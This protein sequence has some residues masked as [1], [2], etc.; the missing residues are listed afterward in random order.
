LCW[1]G[2]SA[3]QP[4]LGVL[5]LLGANLFDAGLA[6]HCGVCVF[7]EMSNSG[8]WVSGLAGSWFMW[9]ALLIS[10]YHGAMVAE[11]ASVLASVFFTGFA[12]PDLVGV[13]EHGSWF[14][15]RYLAYLFWAG[16]GLAKHREFG[17]RRV[18]GV[19]W[20]ARSF[21]EL[22]TRRVCQDTGSCDYWESEIRRYNPPLHSNFALCA[23][24]VTLTWT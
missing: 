5:N 22:T 16:S 1:D 23:V 21:V 12:S 19:P 7:G 11:A 8:E 24:P 2:G 4:T 13:V 9:L 20:V 6:T 10:L 14:L 15:R 17:S 18:C 3:L